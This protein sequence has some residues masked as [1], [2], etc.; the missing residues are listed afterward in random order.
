VLLLFF[1]SLSVD[2]SS[3][4]VEEEDIS[5][6]SAVVNNRASSAAVEGDDTSN[7]TGTRSF[8]GTIAVAEADDTSSIAAEVI[9][10][11]TSTQSEAADTSSITAV[12]NNRAS[13]ATTEADDVA[14]SIIEPVVVSVGTEGSGGNG[15]TVITPGAPGS[16]QA[17]DIWIV[18]ATSGG[19]T[20][21]MS[22]DWTEIAQF[23]SSGSGVIRVAVWW[24]RYN[25]STPPS[26][27][28]TRSSGSSNRS[29]VAGAIA[30][31][32]CPTGSSPEDAQGT[33]S[34][35]GTASVTINAVTTTGPKSLV[36]VVWVG[37][38]SSGVIE[39]PTLPTGYTATFEDALANTQ[40]TYVSQ[41][42]TSQDTGIGLFYDI[43]DDAGSTGS[44]TF[45][46][47]GGIPWQGIAFA[48]KAT[49]STAGAVGNVVAASIDGTIA[50]TEA[51][52]TSTATG[53]RSFQ[54]TIAQTE[55][56]DTSNASGT[57]L[58]T[59]TTTNTEAAD[60]STASGI[61]L[62]TGTIAQTEGVDTSSIAAAVIVTG[63]IARTEEAD[64]SSISGNIPVPVTGTGT[65]SE[66]AD[67]SAITGIVNNRA[68]SAQ[69]EANDTSTASGTVRYVGTSAASEV[70][71]TSNIAAI[72]RVTGT[73]AQT[74]ALDT[75]ALAGIVFLPVTGTIAVTEANDLATIAGGIPFTG[76]AKKRAKKKVKQKLKLRAVD[77][78]EDFGIKLT[79][80][81][82]V[83]PRSVTVKPAPQ[84]R[85]GS[86]FEWEAVLAKWQGKVSTLK[87]GSSVEIQSCLR[88]KASLSSA[89]PV[90][91]L[92]E[93][94]RDGF[95]AQVSFAY[96]RVQVQTRY[97]SHAP[98]SSLRISTRATD[99][100][101]ED[102]LMIIASIPSTS[103]ERE[104]D[105][106]EELV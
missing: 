58:A 34:N 51:A 19:E 85:T 102:V 3:A 99:P 64:T 42:G 92:A 61:V 12:Q 54:G 63:T 31:R 96:P 2:G 59:G 66:L 50:V 40:N 77:L 33:P 56:A 70:N 80:K 48:L 87:V 24:H 97:S 35:G 25:G 5:T 6:A 103:S 78:D 28:V 29:F 17:D 62:V 41:Q 49:V 15:V 52:D 67:T 82:T 100:L 8:Q 7:A 44:I 10:T 30:V 39:V 60:T 13:S 11:G 91:L 27:N 79:V 1:G 16:S 55:A 84:I 32:N 90:K 21:T 37:A 14:G 18:A 47:D 74:E 22:G 88:V 72:V 23:D 69:T 95:R 94:P 73:I 76:G 93:M 46:L 53:T 45:T 81:V 104:T 71:D 4:A 65:P 43:K 101:L 9:V 68:S 20:M 75:G 83:R 106:E 57:V 26:M 105:E 86:I 98:K 38:T 89:Q 36:L